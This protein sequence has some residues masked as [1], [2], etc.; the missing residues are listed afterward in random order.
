M[1]SSSFRFQAQ[2]ARALLGPALAAAWALFAYAHVTRYVATG[3]W[4]YLLFCAS[5]TLSALLFL[6]RSAP[7]TVSRLPS[8]WLLAIAATFFPFLFMPGAWGVLPEARA[9]L[10]VGAAIQ[11]GGLLSL[12]RSIGI[13][14]AN[15]QIKTGGLYRLVRHPLYASYVLSFSGYLLANTSV[16]NLMVYLSSI[17]L[18]VLR[19]RREERHLA[20]DAAYRQ[21][22]SDVKYR[23]VPLL[24]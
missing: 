1:K 10:A 20:Q 9:L 18:L 21:Y 14:P 16:S 2:A 15:R 19:L 7:R 6:V 4:T 11:F 5:E 13:V 17:T 8:D 22:M 3:D 23:I 24:Y 12:N